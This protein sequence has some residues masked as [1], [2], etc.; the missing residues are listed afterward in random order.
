[1]IKDCIANGGLVLK[2]VRHPGILHYE[3]EQDDVSTLGTC[4]VHVEYTLHGIQHVIDPIDP[5]LG[6]QGPFAASHQRHE[7][8]SLVCRVVYTYSLLSDLC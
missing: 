5:I 2:K 6:W 7:S 3:W 1:M 4:S 8:L